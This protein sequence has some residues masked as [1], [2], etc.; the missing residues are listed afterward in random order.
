MTK[1]RPSP[2]GLSTGQASGSSDADWPEP[3]REP[4][5]C[6]ETGSRAGGVTSPALEKR[7][8]E[9]PLLDMQAL[10]ATWA[11]IYGRPPPKFMSRRLLELAAAYDA[12]AKVYGGLKPATRRKLIQIA[13]ART[14]SPAGAAR[15]KPRAALAPGSRLVREWQGRPHTIEVLEDGFLYAGRRYRSLS[16]IA[17]AITGARWSGPRFFGL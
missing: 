10:R 11:D 14:G 17:R 4:P 7:L 6:A 12:Q 15:R 16:E 2:G 3:A 9:I 8:A 13:S 1:R 5:S